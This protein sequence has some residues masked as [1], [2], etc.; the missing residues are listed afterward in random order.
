MTN[1]RSREYCEIADRLVPH[2]FRSHAWRRTFVVLGNALALAT[3]AAAL[4]DLGSVAILFG[5]GAG[6]CCSMFFGAVLVPEGSM[7]EREARIRDRAHRQSYA[8]ASYLLFPAALI[9]A[10]AGAERDGIQIVWAFVAGCLLFWGV[11]Y[12]IIAWSVPDAET[13]TAT[14]SRGAVPPAP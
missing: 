10:V 13:A 9:A 4:L 7:D 11:P 1:A 14:A 3:I 12:S 6:V 5:L 8:F 2:A